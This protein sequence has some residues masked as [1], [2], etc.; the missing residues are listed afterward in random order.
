MRVKFMYFHKDSELFLYLRDMTENVPVIYAAP[1]QGFTEV[2]WRNAHAQC[3]GGVDAYYTPFVRLEK[4]EIR[5]KDRR[6]VSPEENTVSRLVPQVIASEPEELKV[7]TDFLAS[8][9]YREIDVNMGCPFPLIVR[10][11]KG[12]GILSSPEKVEE[13]LATMKAFPEICFSVKMRLG[14]QDAEEWK[15]LVPLL[16][17]SCVTQVTLHPRI[18][19]Q[20]YK[21]TVDRE[22]FRAFYEACER[23]LVYNGDLLTVADI[24]EVLEAFP[25]LKGVMLGRGLLANPALA[26]AFREGELSES[27]LKARVAQMHR[28]MYLYYHR[29]IEGGEAQLLAKLKTCWE[30]LL[31]ELDK[32]QRKAILKSNRLDGYLRAVEEALR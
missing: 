29:V 31:P 32:K 24:R 14:G 18:G 9:G 6:D 16:N 13:L 4:G 1:L 8:Q 12:A 5:N 27:E 2:A 7:L 22:A 26:L 28:Q 23:P 25:R 20:Q 17:R 3:L 19:K 15:A 11:G 10:R 30:Y 21:G